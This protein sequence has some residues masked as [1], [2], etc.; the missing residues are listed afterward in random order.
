MELLHPE[1]LLE[2]LLDSVAEVVGNDGDGKHDHDGE[3]DWRHLGDDLLGAQPIVQDLKDLGDIEGEQLQ[4][5][6]WVLDR[7][8]EEGTEVE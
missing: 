4:V 8:A 6:F 1:P 3:P 5:A 2:A 7:K